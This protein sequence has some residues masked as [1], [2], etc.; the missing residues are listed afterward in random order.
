HP[1]AWPRGADAAVESLDQVSAPVAQALLEAVRGL[2]AGL[3]GPGLTGPGLTGPGLAG[4]GLAGPGE[5]ALAAHARLVAHIEQ[6][7]ATGHPD[8]ALGGPGLTA[9]MSSAEAM[10]VDLGRLAGQADAERDRL[11]ALLADGCAR[12]DPGSR[13]RPPLEGARRA[14]PGPS[15]GGGRW[16]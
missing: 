7:A 8:P 6:S 1:A 13:V 4:P 16:R 15:P 5:A 2:S 3:T 12:L 11:H 14:G 10:P 9:L